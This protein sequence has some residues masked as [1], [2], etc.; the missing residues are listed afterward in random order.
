MP[1]GVAKPDLAEIDAKL[2]AL[3]A[4]W[5]WA[6]P[7]RYARLPVG[8]ILRS[9]R[10]EETLG[11]S[12]ASTI[13]TFGSESFAV[14][15]PMKRLPLFPLA[16]ASVAWASLAPTTL[17]AEE[18]MLRYRGLNR[19][20]AVV[21]LANLATTGEAPTRLSDLLDQVSLSPATLQSVLAHNVT[22]DVV[23]LD[24]A[25]NSLPGEWLLDQLGQAIR[26]V[27][28]EASRQALRS[29]L[30]LSA[31]DDGALTLLE[32]LQAYPAETVVL[33][34]EQIQS[35]M[36]RMETFLQPISHVLGES[37]LEIILR[38]GF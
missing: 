5:P 38:G 31:S 28:G 22:T 7:R 36:E 4:D 13:L 27:S 18:V 20:V 2:T 37:L 15:A 21:D 33:E 19:T 24:K 16:L 35:F 25:L 11:Q 32:I 3:K 17:A 34:V 30:V 12:R 10:C 29:A 14:N 26:P 23:V 8:L 1:D 6:A 9:H